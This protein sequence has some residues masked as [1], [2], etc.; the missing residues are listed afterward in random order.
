M[1]PETGY[2]RIRDIIGDRARNIPALIPVCA[3]SW[4]AGVASGRYP[5]GVLIGPKT[6][7]WKVE[8]I[9][10]LIVEMGVSA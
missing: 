6:R 2:L 3:A 9:K 5:K 1:L 8:D 4:Y 7:A 10:A